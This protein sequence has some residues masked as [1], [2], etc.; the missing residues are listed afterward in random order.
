M[1]SVANLAK[2]KSRKIGHIYNVQINEELQNGFVG[3][4]G[5][6]VSGESELRQLNKF[7][8]ATIPTA[9]ACLIF[10]DEI[11]YDESTYVNKQLG[12]FSISANTP[13]RAYE[14]NVGDE[15][16]IS[17]DGL[18]L[19]GADAVVGNV[20]IPADA[21]LKLTEAASAGT[22]KT[23]LKIEAVKSVGTLQYVGSNG[24]VGNQY[25]MVVARVLSV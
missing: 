16:E 2:V 5:D 7:A 9:S 25:K 17:Y 12:Q 11:N 14:L 8:T 23:V 10:M 19:L 4:V 6:L 15:V 13:A 21:S 22:A 18:T 24:Q 3:I 1:K 20:L